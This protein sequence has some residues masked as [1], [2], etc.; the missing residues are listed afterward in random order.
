MFSIRYYASI[1]STDYLFSV[2]SSNGHVSVVDYLLRVGKLN[3]EDK[4][5]KATTALHLASENGKLEVV[6]LLLK[7]GAKV[8][9][10]DIK[11]L[12]SLHYAATNGNVEIIKLLLKNDNSTLEMEDVNGNTPFLLA[13]W[14]GNTEAVKFFILE[15]GN[16]HISSWNLAHAVT[17]F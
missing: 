1:T 11:N 3:I 7:N 9:T 8:K 16:A 2:A 4:N 14:E 10:L 5:V 15:A 13:A 17:D 12:T 6:S